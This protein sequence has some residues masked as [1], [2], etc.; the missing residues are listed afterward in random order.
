VYRDIRALE[1][2]GVPLGA[3]AGK[4]YYLIEGYHLPPVMFTKNEAGAILIAEKLVNKLADKSIRGYFDSASQK[5]K[6]VLPYSEKEFLDNLNNRV[7]V[8]ISPIMA[9]PDFPNSFIAE[10]Q[11]ALAN[12]QCLQMDYYAGYRS[13]VTKNR[14]VEPVGLVFYGMAWHLIAYCRLR[15][16]YRD[17][18]IDRVKKMHTLDCGYTRRREDEL[19]HYFDQLMVQ[20]EV[21]EVVVHVKKKVAGYMGTSRYYF[22][23]ISETLLEEDIAMKFAVEEF[24]PI[25][26]WLISFGKAVH[27]LKPDKLKKKII[28][29]VKELE[30]HY[31]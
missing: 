18:R 2:A 27:I 24:E 19:Q 28:Q 29:I 7:Q 3:E 20:G 26:R 13:E 11:K 12:S 16:N 17:F 10:I 31:L 6:A 14:V 22:G 23:F 21:H 15:S 1:E 30:T 4:G 5:I 8:Y 25:A 9:A